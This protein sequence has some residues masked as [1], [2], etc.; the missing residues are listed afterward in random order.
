MTDCHH[1]HVNNSKKGFGGEHGI[2]ER[3]KDKSAVG[4]DYKATVEKHSSQ[5]DASKGF[6]GKYGVQKEEPA[7][8][9]I[10]PSSPKPPTETKVIETPAT[11]TSSKADVGNIR[12]KFENM[13]K[14]QE[15]ETA[16]RIADVR[17]NRVA[18]EQQKQQSNND[19]QENVKQQ[20]TIL[21][22]KETPRE[23]SPTRPKTPTE[24]EV[25]TTNQDENDDNNIETVTS[26]TTNEENK[27]NPDKFVG[28]INVTS[29]LRQ[30]KTSSSSSKK[31]DDEDDWGIDKDK[32]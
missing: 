17:K 4:F 27:E 8:P 26:S 18:T 5:T 22:T 19:D 3:A 6:G 32:N 29:L 31:D 10:V 7:S 2:D 12:G 20:E 9:R 13:K 11:V 1:H 30:R 25:S 28:G 16:K 21:T 23:P 15:S 14:E 24:P